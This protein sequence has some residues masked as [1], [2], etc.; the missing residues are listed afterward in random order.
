MGP[1]REQSLRETMKDMMSVLLRGRSGA[2]AVAA[3][4]LTF[5]VP[6]LADTP[7]DA[8]EVLQQQKPPVL[9]APPP[10][11]TVPVQTAQA[12][13][14]ASGG[15]SV[16]IQSVRIVGNTL[17]P[18][19]ALLGVLGPIDGK[20]YD[21]AGLRAITDRLAEFYHQAGY[22]FAVAYLP[23][24]TVE[25]GNLE[26][27]V[28][29][30]RYG[31]V[32]A[33]G[34][35]ALARAAQ[36][37]LGALKSGDPITNRPLE[38]ATLIL[39]DQP[40]IDI[41]PV[42]RPGQEVG[43][44]DLDVLV[45]YADR[46]DG[47]AGIDNY[48]NRYIGQY[49]THVNLNLNSPFL[50]GD[51]ITAHALVTNQGMWFGSLGYNLPLGYDGWRGI[52]GYAHTYYVLGGN[53][54]TLHANGTADVTSLGASYPIVRSQKDDLSFSGLYQ[55]K[56]LHDKLD[57][58]KFEST[59]SSDSLPMA[60]RFDERDGVAGGGVAY[61]ALTWT[62][63]RL[64]LDKNLNAIDVA[65]AHTA[66]S[67]NKLNLDLA[68][69]QYVI[70]SWSLYGR[71][72]FQWANKN[73][74]SS[75]KFGLGGPNGVRA[76]PVGEGFGDKG[77]LGQFEARYAMGSLSPY[78]F[79]DVGSVHY[80]TS[81]WIPAEAKQNTRTIAGTGLGARYRLQHWTFDASLAWRTVGGHP[82]TDTSDAIPRIWVSAIYR[83]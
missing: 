31:K 44:G 51:Q 79:Y 80:N 66:G 81:P 11:T 23:P 67:Y 83:F 10:A 70:R 54:S 69:D 36:P 76:Y 29:E 47:D 19:A 14:A 63:G 2:I 16:M 33:S 52:A 18:E 34:D 37:F 24:Q 46:I 38:R 35:P 59:K 9:Q 25:G 27:D 13:A 7:P 55:H 40:G 15:T 82:L 57:T 6:A 17:Y 56:S 71:L 28:V 45:Q 30:G 77:W 60:L 48:G 65:S 12:P 58:L 72:S 74:D 73:L 75:E 26:I 4:C 5:A 50:F 43:T 61:G 62:P 32:E 41:S 21:L 1:A 64:H 78:A 39:N 42:I 49:Q 3:A 68:R 53:F 22:P 8:G 20:S